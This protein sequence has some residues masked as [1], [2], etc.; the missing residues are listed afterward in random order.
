MIDMNAT[1]TKMTLCMYFNCVFCERACQDTR[2]TRS[3]IILVS[4]AG[5]R[6]VLM[7]FIVELDECH[8]RQIVSQL[9]GF[10]THWSFLARTRHLVALY[11][12]QNSL[13]RI[14]AQ[15]FRIS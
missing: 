4:C 8:L 14:Y 7:I 12:L 2:H 5:E 3:H 11:G 6:N 1:R 10:H 15:M 13:E 9:D